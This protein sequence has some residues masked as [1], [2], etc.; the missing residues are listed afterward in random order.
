MAVESGIPVQLAL[1]FVRSTMLDLLPPVTKRNDGD[2]DGVRVVVAVRK[3][4][5]IKVF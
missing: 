3:E 5:E 4:I 2:V 1:S